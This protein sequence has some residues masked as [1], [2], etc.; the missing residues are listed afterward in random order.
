VQGTAAIPDRA[1]VVV[2]GGGIIGTS[3]AYHLAHLGMSDVVLL[4]R[5]RLTSGTTWHAAGLMA[6]FGSTSQTSTELR[7]YTRDLYARL[8][9]ETG[10]ATGLKQCGLIELA[11]EPGRLEEYRQVAAFNRLCGVEVHEISAREVAGLWPLARVD[12]V[13]AGFYIPADGRVN[14]VDVTMSLARGARMQGARIIEGVPVTGFMHNG[15]AV[16][17]V[18]TPHGDIEAE[19]VVNC[20]GMWARELGALAGVT[21]PLQA[22]EHY[23]LLTEPIEGVGGDWPVLEDPAS[24]GYYREEGGGLMLGLFEPVCAPWRLAGVPADFSFGEIPPDW[25]RMAP[26]LER[27]MSRVPVVEETGIKKLFCGPESF[28]PDLLP[29]VGEAPELRNYFVAAGLNSIGILTGGGIGRVVAQWI[30]DGWPDVDVTAMNIDRLHPYQANPEYRATRTVESLG[31]V[32]ETHFPGRPMR[33]ARGAKVSPIHQRLVEQR[34]YF[35]DVSGW[36]GADWYAPEGAVPEGAAPEAGPLSWGRPDWFGYWEAEHHATR[37]G[38]V[39]MDMAFMAK[40]GV[41]GR[42]AGQVLEQVSANHVDG[43]PGR[44]TYT[45]WLN[46]GGTLEA[47]LTVTKLDE[48][49]FWV[50]ASDTAHRHAETWLRRHIGDAHAS[51]TDVTS[52]YAQINI[53]GPRSRELLSSVTDA[54]LSNEAFPFRTAAEIAIGFARVLCIRITY[55][56]E[57]GYELYIPAEQSV[58]VY[59]RLVQAGHAVGLR[60]AGLKALGSLR[61]EKGYRDYGHDIDNT[62]TVL[63]AGLGFAVALDKPGG[64]IGR[65]TVLAQKERGPLRRRLVQV[66]VTDPEPLMFHAEV[67]RRDG[68]PAGYIRS[69][70]YGFTLGGAVGL[71]MIDAGEPINQAYLDA[72]EWTVQI[73]DAVYPA[74]ASL[75]PMYDPGNK[76]IQA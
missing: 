23:Y 47:D 25:D 22:A 42:D 21:I 1:R 63:E 44:I 12:D 45:Q 39:L 28:T 18:R 9:A 60:H 48:D 50:V 76:R 62:D 38:V 26:Y 51:V 56:G 55:L 6:T 14:P 27:T 52:G 46:P 49:R 73:G 5:D 32:Y 70:S 16:A 17:G 37:T 58:H 67:V 75:R 20:A 74:V 54:D 53:Q 34:A 3:V 4:E 65:D 43:E 2:I 15:G 61:M 19:Y 30:A 10:L 59:D 36:E 69:A 11:I 72:G 8:E 13:L 24:Y 41:Q 40:F 64:F 66:L 29:I 68:R 7:M 33:T 35:R 71:A 57:L 31:M